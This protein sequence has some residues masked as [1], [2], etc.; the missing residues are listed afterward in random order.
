MC[1][2]RR[3]YL[4]QV[5]LGLSGHLGH[6]LGAVDEEEEGARLVGH[7]TRDERLAGPGGAVQQHTPD[8]QRQRREERVRGQSTKL[9][10]GQSRD[11]W[12]DCLYGSKG[13]GGRWKG[14]VPG[15]LD[16]EGLEEGGVAQGQ[17]DHLTDLAHL[18]AAPADVVVAHVV[19]ALLV[20]HSRKHNGPV[21]VSPRRRSDLIMGLYAGP[22]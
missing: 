19:Q 20:L 14:V 3:A 9:K 12:E 5:G 22:Y 18:A 13:V 11:K 17:L 2:I 16:T 15:G 21:G 4:A 8:R 1:G 6:D 7:G 10:K